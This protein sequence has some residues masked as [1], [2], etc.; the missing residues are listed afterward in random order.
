[1]SMG[2]YYLFIIF[3]GIVCGGFPLYFNY[4][5]KKKDRELQQAQLDEIKNLKEEVKNLKK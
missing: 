2:Y 3:M 5:R 4:R 1:M